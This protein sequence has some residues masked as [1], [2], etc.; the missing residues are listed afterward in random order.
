MAEPGVGYDPGCYLCPGN[1]RASGERNPDYRDTHVFLNDFPALLPTS[2]FE[3]STDSL[4]KSEPVRGECRVICYSPRHDLTMANMRE[5]EIAK[6]VSIWS[7]QAQEL[8]ARYAYVQ[9]FENKGPAMG[10]SNPHPH[11]QI[12]ASGHVPSLV[13]R[14]LVNQ[15]EYFYEKAR[16]LLDDVVEAESGGPRAVAENADWLAVVPFWATWPFET[17]IVAKQPISSLSEIE[18]PLVLA[19]VLKDL[20]GR[21]DRLFGVSFPYSFGWHSLAKSREHRLHAHIYPPLLRSAS[22]RKFMVGYEML[23]EA[24]RDLTPEDA[25]ARLRDV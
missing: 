16:V 24:Q 17:L 1:V 3:D 9:V 23:G 5:G 25:A 15:E 2:Q 8:E 6:V 14:E 19:S 18:D 12:W 4:L 22:I 13:T 20:L 10:C 21:Y 7:S 11:G